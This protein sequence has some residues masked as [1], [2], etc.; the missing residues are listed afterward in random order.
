MAVFAA[1]NYSIVLN[2]VD[3]SNHGTKV[4]TKWEAKDLDVTAFGATFVNRIGGLQDWTG[5]IEFNQD[6]ASG[7]V[8]ATISSIVGTVV[9]LTVQPVAGARSATNPGFQGNVLIKSYTPLS[10]G[11]VG[12]VSKATVE[13]AA[14]GTMTRLTS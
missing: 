1:T 12:D 6:F 13:F 4:D 14:A 10:A 2:S 8:D 3:L 7:S 11:A 5:T 9:Q